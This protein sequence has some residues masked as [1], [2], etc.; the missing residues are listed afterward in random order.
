MFAASRALLRFYRLPECERTLLIEAALLLPVVHAVQT[1]LPFKR[2]RA[3]LTVHA[4]D[5]SATPAATNPVAAPTAPQVAQAI[6]RARKGVPGIYK[7]LPQAYAGHLLLHRHGHASRVQVGVARDT[8]G[9]VEAHA[10]VEWQGKVLIGQLPDLAR[11][12]PLP[13]LQV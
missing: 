13:P 7:C 8:K 12:V 1:V 6:E 5:N 11:F 3:L 9:A 10:W 2:W 4:G